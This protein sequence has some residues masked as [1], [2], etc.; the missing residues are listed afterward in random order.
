M[1]ASLPSY[2][3]SVV[4]YNT[5]QWKYNLPD[6][7]CQQACNV[8]FERTRSPVLQAELLYLP[9]EIGS[10]DLKQA[11]SFGDVPFASLQRSL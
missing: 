5:F 4:L 1:S 8:G 2:A 6:S 10:I 9:G 3:D 7:Q 11:R